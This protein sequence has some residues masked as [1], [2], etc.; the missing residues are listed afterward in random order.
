MKNSI[1]R[2]I[3]KIK[4]LLYVDKQNFATMLDQ[5][6][7]ETNLTR[8]QNQKDHFCSFFLPIHQKSKSIYLGDHIKAGS[9]IPPGGHIELDESPIDT[10][11]R[12]FQEELQ[13]K[14]KEKDIL[15]FDVSITHI[16]NNPRSGS[17]KTHFDIWYIVNISEKIDFVFDKK[18]YKDAKWFSFEKGVQKVTNLTYN[19]I[20]NKIQPFFNGK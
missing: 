20:V 9:W 6:D 18:E 4:D 15:I 14:P 11:I 19:K 10:V 7:K 3:L 5:I 16:K 17:C 1:R 8:P 12:E 2:E 13:Y